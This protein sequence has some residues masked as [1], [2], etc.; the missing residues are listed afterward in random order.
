MRVISAIAVLACCGLQSA[1]AGTEARNTGRKGLMMDQELLAGSRARLASRD[2][3]LRPALERLIGDA[4]KAL[5]VGPFSVVDKTVMP[6]SGDKHDYTSLGGYWWPNPKTANGLPYVRRD[7]ELNPETRTEATD[8]RRQARMVSAVET[9]SLAYFFTGEEK[10]AERAALLL[11]TWFLAPATRMNPHLEYGQAIPGRTKGRGIGIIDTAAFVRVPDAVMLLAGSPAWTKRDQDGLEKWFRAYL[12]W[13][14]ESKH[15]RDE[16]RAPNNHGT[17]YDAQVAAFALFVGDND[18]ATRVFKGAKGRIAAQVRPDGSQPAELRRTRSFDYSVYNLQA[19]CRLARLA[20]HVDV[21]LW[22]FESEK[23]GGIRKAIDFLAPYAELGKKWPYKQITATRRE[24]LL[25]LLMQAYRA[26][27]DD[28]YRVAAEHV[29][30]GTARTD[31]AWLV[32]GGAMLP[33]AD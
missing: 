16:A 29:A 4:G 28:R 30:P 3:A 33:P 17:W 1:S 32:W 23:G 20:E 2:R 10:Y 9:L 5:G 7:G 14:R 13:L 19:F 6:P 21:D 26:Y 22:R 18:T 8:S 12:N 15:G 24:R 31:R 27:R 25:P 11:R